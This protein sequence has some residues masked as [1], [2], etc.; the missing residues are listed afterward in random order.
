[1]DTFDMCSESMTLCNIADSFYWLWKK[2][3]LVSSEI[4]NETWLSGSPV[5][6]ED[7]LT[8]RSQTPLHL[9][10]TCASY[11]DCNPMLL[12]WDRI[13]TG[14]IY[15]WLS[16]CSSVILLWSDHW[17]RTLMQVYRRPEC[18]YLTD[19]DAHTCRRLASALRVTGREAGTSS[20]CRPLG[21]LSQRKRVERKDE[22]LHC[23]F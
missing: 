15:T 8:L 17:N 4:C 7:H 1:M 16:M 13:E 12:Q 18:C 21:N 6:T 9:V 2:S 14:C 3:K 11:L 10:L 5:L 23:T 20:S 19:E 22:W